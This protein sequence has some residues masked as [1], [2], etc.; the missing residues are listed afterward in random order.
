MHRIPYFL[1]DIAVPLPDLPTN[2]PST[3]L[4]RLARLRRQLRR[5]GI[6][7]ERP[8]N[9]VVGLDYQFMGDLLNDHRDAMTEEPLEYLA[10]HALV[11]RSRPIS[12]IDLE[13]GCE[14]CRFIGAP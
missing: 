7:V 10:K 5:G 4:D 2:L 8:Q 9:Q 12:L 6:L 14:D 11:E 1:R 13:D 3:V